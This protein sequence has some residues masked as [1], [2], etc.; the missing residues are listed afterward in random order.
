MAMCLQ[1]NLMMKKK[2]DFSDALERAYDTSP[3]NDIKIVL[4]DFNA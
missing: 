1:R 4:S 3:R 2:M